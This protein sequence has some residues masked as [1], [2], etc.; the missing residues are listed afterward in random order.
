MLPTWLFSWNS[1]MR[2]PHTF[3]CTTQSVTPCSYADVLI[4]KMNC[5][6]KPGGNHSAWNIVR[7]KRIV[8]TGP[9]QPGAP[10]AGCRQGRGVWLRSK[11]Q[12]GPSTSSQLAEPAVQ[13][14]DHLLPLGLNKSTSRDSR[15]IFCVPNHTLV[16]THNAVSL[17]LSLIKQSQSPSRFAARYCHV[18]RWAL[19]QHF[20][21]R[22]SFL[23]QWI[24]YSTRTWHGHD[25]CMRKRLS[26]A[27]EC[28]EAG[29]TNSRYEEAFL[30]PILELSGIESFSVVPHL[31]YINPPY[32]IPNL[33]LLENSNL[34]VGA[35][36]FKEFHSVFSIIWVSYD[37]PCVILCP[38]CVISSSV[39]CNTCNHNAFGYS[40]IISS[41]WR[42]GK[43]RT[44][45]VPYRMH[46]FNWVTTW[47]CTHSRI[48]SCWYGSER[49]DYYDISWWKTLYKHIFFFYSNQWEIYSVFFSP[50]GQR[51]MMHLHSWSLHFDRY[52]FLK[53]VEIKTLL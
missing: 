8:L 9:L 11:A 48:D 14:R 19:L 10:V 29:T 44:I 52:Y 40:E 17:L 33:M 1:V 21:L 13:T 49:N 45:L 12:L 3:G 46:A 32:D 27:R 7:R 36:M 5:V 26:E 37:V 42:L 4:I 50:K 15:R 2:S 41:Y 51:A 23:V 24:L 25:K 47:L 20:F 35:K 43:I 30:C 39:K 6:R 16:A 28:E 18:Q 34:L 38:V 31:R 53:G 22:K